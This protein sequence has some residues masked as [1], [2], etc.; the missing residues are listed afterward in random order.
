MVA[1][2]PAGFG[3]EESRTGDAVRSKNGGCFLETSDTDTVWRIG[4][5]VIRGVRV[6]TPEIYDGS[7]FRHGGQHVVIVTGAAA[8][9]AGARNANGGIDRVKSIG[10][11]VEEPGVCFGLP[12]AVHLVV[13]FD[14][15]EPK[16]AV[17]VSLHPITIVLRDRVI[18]AVRIPEGLPP[19]PLEVVG[20]I[21]ADEDGDD[22][23]SA[24][25]NEIAARVVRVD[26]LGAQADPGVPPVTHHVAHEID[27]PVRRGRVVVNPE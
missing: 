14:I 4:W 7:E 25:K 23:M 2:F 11:V 18:R 24:V 27:V 16:A 13:K 22:V 12:G 1:E 9:H 8:R 15:R 20:E 5:R 10:D 3:E 26:P 19:G 6:A 17:H 21:P